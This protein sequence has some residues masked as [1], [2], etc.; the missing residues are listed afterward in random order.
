LTYYSVP[1][2]VSTK[3]S[4]ISTSF[5][6]LLFPITVNLHALNN[7]DKIKRIFIRSVRLIAI[8]AS[9]IAFSIIFTADKILLYWLD[10]SFVKQSLN[11][12]IILVI[13]NFVLAIFSPL[14]NLLMAMGKMKFLT[15]SSFIMAFINI[16]ALLILLPRH[17]INGA[18]WAYLI[19]VLFIFG[20]F[21]YAERNFFQIKENIILNLFCKLI[22]TAIPF[23]LIVNFLLKPMITSMPTLIVIGPICVLLFMLLY[24]LLGFVEHEDW[25]DFRLSLAKFV[26]KLT[27]KN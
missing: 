25:N 9:S 13:T 24:K 11:V 18:A 10:E 23:Y 17:G 1:G 8:L 16:F 2:G 12:L 27:F 14:S 4:Q 26:N 19:S 21:Y 15:V 6:S 22:F 20:M 5:S 7:T 3:I